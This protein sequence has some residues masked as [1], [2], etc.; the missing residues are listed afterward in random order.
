MLFSIHLMGAAFLKVPEL[1]LTEDESKQLGDAVTRVTELYEV[2]LMDEKTLAWVNLAIVAS[3]IYGP[4]TV[5]VV[6]NKKKEAKPTIVPPRPKP[7]NV[8][9]TGFAEVVM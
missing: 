4:R 6:V 3:G 8:V 5:A 1:M 2:P 7:T 9:Q